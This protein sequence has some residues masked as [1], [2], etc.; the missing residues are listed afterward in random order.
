MWYKA[1]TVKSPTHSVYCDLLFAGYRKEKAVGEITPGYCRCNEEDFAEMASLAPNV[2]FIF[3]MRDPVSRLW[4]GCRHR[5]RLELGRDGTTTDAVAER[6]LSS[7]VEPGHAAF[8]LSSYDHT[9]RSLENVVSPDKIA[10]FFYETLFQ[11]SEI[12]RLCTFL[13]VEHVPAAIDKKVHVGADASGSM[14]PDVARQA[15]EALRP[16]YEF[17]KAKFGTLPP[18]WQHEAVGRDA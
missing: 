11:Q 4:S 16:T 12:D 1:V 15:R 14:P 18:E 17:C 7:L 13:G 3:I 8:E 10:Y 9:I 5:L 6:L 2:R